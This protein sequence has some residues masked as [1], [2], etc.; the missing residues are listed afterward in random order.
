MDGE[1]YIATGEKWDEWLEELEREMRFFRISEATDMKDTMLIYG[2]T[3]IRRLEKSL[4]DPKEGDAYAKLKG[5]LTDYFSP[6]KNIHYARYLFLK[7]KPHTDE[8]TIVCS[9]ITGKSKELW[10]SSVCG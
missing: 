9:T 4:S 2:D 6:K 5:K 1:D 3:E 8:I 7:M 10:I